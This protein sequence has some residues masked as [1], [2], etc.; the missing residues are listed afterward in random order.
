LS[1]FDFEPVRGLPAKL[2]PGETLL[3]QGSPDWRALA[4]RTF[5]VKILLGYFS[6]LIAWK[7]I[8]AFY[9]GRSPGE[10][11]SGLALILTLV[12]ICIGIL[13]LLAWGTARTTVYSI[14][15]KRVV[16]RYGIALTM[17][18]NIPF[19]LINS[20]GLRLYPTGHGDIPLSLQKG[21][22]ISYLMLWPHARPWRMKKPEPMLRGIPDAA[23]TAEILGRALAM[24]ASRPTARKLAVTEAANVQRLH[25]P[26]KTPEIREE[27]SL[28]DARLARL[29]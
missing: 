21:E 16:I 10:T 27:P 12:V 7:I 25:Q 4:A 20:A 2:P 29:T 23:A 1:D 24:A 5:K 13:C 15:D 14:T 9:D 22:K 3:W 11:L 18:L 19:K 6:V 17:A 8:T 26:A 28:A